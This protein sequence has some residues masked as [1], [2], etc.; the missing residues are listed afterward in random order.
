M[1]A[2]AAPAAGQ[3]GSFVP[4]PPLKW[5]A[6]ESLDSHQ[7]AH[8]EGVDIVYWK[9]V[10]GQTTN[11]WIYVT[12]WVTEMDGDTVVGTRF[13]T[14]RYDAA[15]DGSGGAPLPDKTAYF[16]PLGTG[17]SSGDTYKAV[18]MDIDPNT[19]DIYV[20]GEAPRPSGSDQD[21]LVIR[22]DKE[23]APLWSG[24]DGARYYDGPVNGDDIPADVGVAFDNSGDAVAVVVTGTSPGD[25]TGLDIATVAWLTSSGNRA[26]T[27]WPTDGAR[28]YNH[29]P[30]D[31]DDRAVELGGARVFDIV[32]T[33]VLRVIVLGTSYG[34]STTLDD[35]TTHQWSG[36]STSFS[37]EARYNN[38]GNDVARGLAV[39]AD[40]S[41]AYV[42]GY[43]EGASDIDYATVS[44]FLGVQDWA[45]REDYVGEDDYPS[46]IH[47]VVPPSGDRQVWVTG[48]GMDG[49]YSDVFTVRYLDDLSGTGVWTEG[50]GSSLAFEYGRGMTVFEDEPYI[51]GAQGAQGAQGGVPF[52]RMLALAYRQDS[53]YV[54]SWNSAFSGPYIGGTSN[55]GRG[56]VAAVVQ[57]SD[58]D[59]SVYLVGV[60]TESG[61]G[62]QF[63]T[64][65]FKEE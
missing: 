58:S 17:I 42:T 43:S 65:R 37:W 2:L 11:H 20:T 55:E 18:A 44:Y 16:P 10:D 63:T 21:Y 40:G 53:P 13:A 56:V 59:R 35:Y 23:L 28:R 25:G 41:Y 36:T 22:Y 46:D 8:D 51:A 15:D 31:G 30:E 32:E 47:L 7:D 50:F 54:H 49:T 57:T 61:E 52:D 34:G 5:A 33:P 1:A 12:G 62:R 27:L 39:D 64:L 4:W 24:S 9:E 45:E 48:A 6:Q 26:S 60:A 38:G 3:S 29:D 19:G 14:F